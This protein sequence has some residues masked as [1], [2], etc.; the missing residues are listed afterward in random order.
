D[1]RLDSGL[2]AEQLVPL[3]SY[4]SPLSTT[5]CAEPYAAEIPAAGSA[6][7]TLPSNNPLP[8]PFAEQGTAPALIEQSNIVGAAIGAAPVG[9]AAPFAAPGAPQVYTGLAAS[10]SS[11]EMPDTSSPETTAALTPATLSSL[12]AIAQPVEAAQEP[13]TLPPAAFQAPPAQAAPHAVRPA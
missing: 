2:I 13:P 1:P 10:G 11:L 12:P 4:H 9:V 8:L 6:Y 3:P 5:P 7:R